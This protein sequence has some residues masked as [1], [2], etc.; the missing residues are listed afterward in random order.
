MDR[1][2]DVNFIN[3]RSN[4]RATFSN[5]PMQVVKIHRLVELGRVAHQHREIIFRMPVI[6]EIMLVVI[7][8]EAE[9]KVGNFIPDSI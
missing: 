8:V 7:K 1:T 4:Q 3:V 5:G 6:M 9:V 2:K